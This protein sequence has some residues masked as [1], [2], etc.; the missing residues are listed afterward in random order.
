[1]YLRPPNY[2]QNKFATANLF[3]R[4]TSVISGLTT[5]SNFKIKPRNEVVGH[6]N[7]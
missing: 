7:K 1:M 6:M 5:G 4:Q 2:L 3:F